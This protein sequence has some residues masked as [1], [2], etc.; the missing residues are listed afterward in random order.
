MDMKAASGQDQFGN[1]DG[2]LEQKPKMMRESFWRENKKLCDKQQ[3][4]RWSSSL[5]EKSTEQLFA[6][7]FSV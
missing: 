7:Y 1:E 4:Q 5:E 3:A 6:L 2:L